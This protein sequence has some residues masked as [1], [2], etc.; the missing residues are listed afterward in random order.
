MS[1]P[2]RDLIDKHCGGVRGGWDNLQAVIPGGSSVP[3]L[4]IDECAEALMDFDDLKAAQADL[5]LWGDANRV[6]FDPAKESFHVL[7]SRFHYGDSFKLLGTVFDGALL[8]HQA[9][10]EVATEGGWRLQTLLKEQ[11]VTLK[12]E[13]ME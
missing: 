12:Q 9:A 10:R 2:F 4:P 6:L 8:M 7:H 13:R 3:V 1:I 11:R 5:H